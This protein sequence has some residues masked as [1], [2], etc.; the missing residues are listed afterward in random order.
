MC[1][2]V[3][4]RRR[5][6]SSGLH[7]RGD[8]RSLALH[9]SNPGKSGVTRVGSLA[10][11]LG[12]TQFDHKTRHELG[13]KRELHRATPNTSRECIHGLKSPLQKK[14]N[15]S[16][17]AISTS[18]VSP[19]LSYQP[20]VFQGYVDGQKTESRGRPIYETEIV[21][22]LVLMVLPPH[23]YKTRRLKR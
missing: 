4:R 14:K 18:G 10:K 13:E 8:F 5:K 1:S 17:A 6:G 22:P 7:R 12:R 11:K 21:R 9:V 15:R 16:R 2:I 19:Q 23:S 20:G 3:P